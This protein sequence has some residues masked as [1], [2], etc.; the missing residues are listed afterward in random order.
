VRR[1]RHVL[2]QLYGPMRTSPPGFPAFTREL[3]QEADRVNAVLPQQDPP[4][5]T[6]ASKPAPRSA[7]AAHQ[8]P[9]FPE[10][11]R[12]DSPTPHLAARDDHA[13]GC[14]PPAPATLIERAIIDIDIIELVS[15][16]RILPRYR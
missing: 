1:W 2:C 12:S 14:R 16:L 11:S 6:A 7:T 15:E 9:S 13:T 3:T 4:D 8:S 10:R 5:R